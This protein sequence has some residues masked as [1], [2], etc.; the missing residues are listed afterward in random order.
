VVLVDT[1]QRLVEGEVVGIAE[2][3]ALELTSE[4]GSS[5]S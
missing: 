1:G 3:G 2:D 5:A 4:R